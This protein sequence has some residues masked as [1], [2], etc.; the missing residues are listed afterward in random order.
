MNKTP[1]DIIFQKCTKN[2][3]Y[4]MLYCSWVMAHDRY[5]CYFSFWTIFCPFTHLTGQK[6]KILKKLKKKHMEISSFYICI[7]KIMIRCTVTEIW[8]MTDGWTD[9]WKKWHI[10]VGAAPK[11]IA[12][13]QV[14]TAKGEG[15]YIHG[16]IYIYISCSNSR[17]MLTKIKWIITTFTALT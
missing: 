14:Y 15:N 11:N 3:D 10:E 7:P 12:K 1:G 9:G 17:F 16:I 13:K 8:C 6:I 2:H 5:N 4:H